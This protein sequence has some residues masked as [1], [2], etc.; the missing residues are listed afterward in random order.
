M[1][2]EENINVLQVVNKGISTGQATNTIPLL[3][4]KQQIFDKPI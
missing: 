2:E 3:P 1:K 4:L